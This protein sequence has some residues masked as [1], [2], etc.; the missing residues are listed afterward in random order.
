MDFKTATTEELGKFVAEKRLVS[1]GPSDVEFTAIVSGIEPD[2]LVIW[3]GIIDL[4][5][6]APVQP[7]DWSKS[8]PKSLPMGT[9]KVP[10]H[11]TPSNEMPGMNMGG[12]K[13]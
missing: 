7:M 4:F 10:G 9:G 2:D 5:P 6:E 12:A 13:K 8:G 11:V 3:A 1:I